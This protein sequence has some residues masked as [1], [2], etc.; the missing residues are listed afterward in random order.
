MQCECDLDRVCDRHQKEQNQIARLEREAVVKHLK[1]EGDA[2]EQI[3]KGA[4][5]LA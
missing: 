5:L 2:A 3:L 1:L 4:H